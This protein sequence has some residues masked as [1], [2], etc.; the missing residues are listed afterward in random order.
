MKFSIWI[1][2]LSLASFVFLQACD[3][4]ISGTSY[5]PLDKGLKWEYQV[6]DALSGEEVIEKSFFSM[7]NLGPSTIK[8][9]NE[10]YNTYVRQGS[11]GNAYYIVNNETGIYRVAKRTVVEFVPRFDDIVRQV[12]PHNTL[13]DI[14]Q[15]WNVD[16]GM[17]VVNGRPEFNTNSDL[18]EKH[19]NMVFEVQSLD[20][21]VDVP[22]GQFENCI[23]IEG[24]VSVTLYA[25]PKLGYVDVPVIQT[26]WYAPNVGLVKM[27]RSEVIN[28]PVYQGGVRTFELTKFTH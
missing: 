22:A 26:E 25:D 16:T 19:L 5:F 20:D 15:L 12:L 8:N 18:S 6:S 23:R 7:E 3:S 13:I 21:V 17:Y 1:K 24:Y 10:I 11:D 14:G 27:V 28:T 4:S 2:W 9:D